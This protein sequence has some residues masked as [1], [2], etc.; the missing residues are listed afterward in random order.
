LSLPECD[1]G[2][3]CQDKYR[4]DRSILTFLPHQQPILMTNSDR[5]IT[6]ETI[7]LEL[8]V[9]NVFSWLKMGGKY[10]HYLPTAIIVEY[11]QKRFLLGEVKP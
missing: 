6:L 8:I 10:T 1:E 7:N 2:K 5:L 3:N 9:E 11:V 4:G